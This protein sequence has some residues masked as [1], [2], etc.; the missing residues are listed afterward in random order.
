M[1]DGLAH[2]S[3]HSVLREIILEHRFI[4]DPLAYF[5]NRNTFDVEVLRSEFDAGG[6]DLIVSFKDITHHVQLKSTRMAGKTTHVSVGT[7]LAERP[8]G[9]VICFE[10]DDTLGVNGYLWFGAKPRLPVPPMDEF[11]VTRHTKANVKGIKA[12]RP[13]H[14]RVSLRRFTPIG[15]IDDLVAALLGP[16]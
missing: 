13:A 2:H 8:P 14:R 15:R 7:K 6:Y 5:W 10:I 11:A 9:C 4:T 12:E 1:T 3:R 16:V